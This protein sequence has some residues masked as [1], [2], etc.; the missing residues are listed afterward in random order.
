[1]ESVQQEIDDCFRA[2]TETAEYV[3]KRKV[4]FEALKREAQQ[5]MAGLEAAQLEEMP[6]EPTPPAPPKTPEPPKPARRPSKPASNSSRKA[7]VESVTPTPPP[8]RAMV[9]PQNQDMFG[10]PGTMVGKGPTGIPT[11]RKNSGSKKATPKG[12]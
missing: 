3:R 1:M 7:S 9:Q 6:R 4:E 8:P 12:K 5:I 10:G 2:A 11:G